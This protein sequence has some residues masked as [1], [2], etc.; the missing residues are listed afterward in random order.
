MSDEMI[1]IL[2]NSRH[3]Y[4]SNRGF[5]KAAENSGCIVGLNSY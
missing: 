4:L 1:I 2:S 5:C 3:Y